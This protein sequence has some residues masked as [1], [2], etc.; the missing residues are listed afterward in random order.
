[1]GPGSG[2]ASTVFIFTQ[3]FV[4]RADILG[5]SSPRQVVHGRHCTK[6]H[7]RSQRPLVLRL[8][9]VVCSTLR[10]RRMLDTMSNMK[11]VT[12]REVQHGLAAVLAEVQRGQEIAVTKRGQVVARIVPAT[13]ARGRLRWPDSAARMERLLAGLETK[14]ASPSEIVQEQRGER[15]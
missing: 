15:L 8:N 1:M 6:V 7:R 12:V 2:D 11:T 4:G 14:G 13:A 3:L 10:L 9:S 5:M